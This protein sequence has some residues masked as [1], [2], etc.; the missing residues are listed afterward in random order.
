MNLL[1][2]RQLHQHVHRHRLHV[3]RRLRHLQERRHLLRELHHRRLSRQA[4]AHLLQ[5]RVLQ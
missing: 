5:E 1:H 4:R 3:P 2:G